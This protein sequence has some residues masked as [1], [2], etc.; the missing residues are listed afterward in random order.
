TQG[1]RWS[2]RHPTLPLPNSG[3]GLSAPRRKPVG[4]MADCQAWGNRWRGPTGIVATVGLG[5]VQH[6]KFHFCVSREILVRRRIQ[7]VTSERIGE[8]E[9]FG[10]VGPAGAQGFGGIVFPVAALRCSGRDARG[11]RSPRRGR[12]LGGDGVRHPLS[13]A[14]PACCPVCLLR[15]ACRD[16]SP[17]GRAPRWSSPSSASWFRSR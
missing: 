4:G 8:Y 3:I 14:P 2:I 10:W 17:S 13:V 11:G 5:H 16:G 1:R 9:V 7:P 12:G 15:A 6:D